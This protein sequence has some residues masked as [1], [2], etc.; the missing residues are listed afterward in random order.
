MVPKIAIFDHN[1]I[2]NQIIKAKFTKIITRIIVHA[3]LNDA[4]HLMYSDHNYHSK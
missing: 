2:K 1:T 4:I 3:E